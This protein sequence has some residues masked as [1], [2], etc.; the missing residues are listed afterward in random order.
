MARKNRLLEVFHLAADFLV[1][2]DDYCRRPYWIIE[3]SGLAQSSVNSL[4]SRLRRRGILDDQNQLVKKRKHILNLVRKPWD[5]HWRMVVYDIPEKERDLRRLIQQ[6]LTELGFGQL[7]RSTWISSLPVDPWLRQLKRQ[8]GRETTFTIGLSRLL[9]S[10][11]RKLVKQL[12]PV[13]QWRKDTEKFIAKIR[14][15]ERLSSGDKRFFWQLIEDHP[16]VSLDLL[17]S[18]WPLENLVH[19]FVAKTKR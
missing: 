2:F 15:K 1:A 14:Q 18:D 19:L 4:I 13:G 7:Q 6:R 12:W 11:P 3:N 17:P 16:R 8:L 10:N 5:G 9:D